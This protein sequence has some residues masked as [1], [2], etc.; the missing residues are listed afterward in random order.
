M[1]SQRPPSGK[2][3]VLPPFTF[4]KVGVSP[5]VFQALPGPEL[6]ALRE[7]SM[8]HFSFF[9]PGG[10]SGLRIVDCGMRIEKKLKKSEIRNSKSEMEGPMLF[11]CNALTS[12]PQACFF[13]EKKTQ[14]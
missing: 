1:L 12:G 3:R 6:R 13:A 10:P 5:V 11:P 9:G 4:Q 8:R 14:K 7:K 2:K